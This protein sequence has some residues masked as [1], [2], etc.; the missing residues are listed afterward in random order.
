[1]KIEYSSNSLRQRHYVPLALGNGSL[2]IMVD[3]EGVQKQQ[4]YC[5]MTP[6]IV[7]AGHRYENKEANLLKYGY[8]DQ[9]IQGA[10]KL[11]YFNQ[12]LDLDNAL[13]ECICQYESNLEVK[14]KIFCHSQK[15]I[16]C[17]SK[18]FSYP[19]YYT[20]KYHTFDGPF[21]QLKDELE[22]D[23]K[24]TYSTGNNSGFIKIVCNNLTL[25]NSSNTN[26]AI[27]KN[28]SCCK[29][30]IYLSFDEEINKDD[31]VENLFSSHIIPW[32]KYWKECSINI[33]DD[34]IYKMY[35][36]AQYHLKISSTAW[37]CPTGIFPTH[38]QGRYFAYDEFYTHGAFLTSGHF[39]EALKI[40]NFRFSIL[41]K[42]I[43][44]ACY[45]TICKEDN[46]AAHF[47]WETLEDGSEGAPE[48]FWMDRY[49]HMVHVAFNAYEYYKFTQD[50]ELLKEKLYPLIKACVQYIFRC[51]IYYDS[52][53]GPYIGKCTD[54]ERFGEF[55][56]RPYS[57]TCGA[58]AVFT[59]AAHCAKVLNIDEALSQ[60][61][62]TLAQQL[63]KSLPI[64][65]GRYVPYIDCPQSS[66]AMYHGIYPFNVIDI[67]NPLQ[68]EAIKDTEI[69][70][71]EFAGQYSKG[72]NLS[73]W[74][75]GV[76]ATA[77][78]RRGNID[79]ALN[80]IKEASLNSTGCFYECFEV[81]ERE[82]LPWFTTASGALIRAINE[83]ISF[84]KEN[85]LNLDNLLSKLSSSNEESKEL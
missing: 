72:T 57:T 10:G 54:M 35:M 44:R 62:S 31:T 47:P 66:I 63:Y 77:E 29:A 8:F 41:P 20:F 21:L 2:S 53:T 27:Y 33:N 70:Q 48:G 11:I 65:D 24:I 17:I 19:V 18:E 55:I 5:S 28:N 32:Q 50:V 84:C 15:D 13:C 43:R 49:I 46:L 34:T 22:T 51:G 73:S 81:Y 83:V 42:V 68:I 60:K 30:E 58:I 6:T 78:A 71:E 69:K 36:V 61:W 82:K 7:K 76:I 4:T 12:I 52:V 40:D 39:D 37:S 45:V 25:N 9:E 14:T 38:W 67:N 3:Q 80:L 1:M 75:A 85:N 26:C 59:A 74:Y 16:I 56:E 79:K 23:N 64:Q